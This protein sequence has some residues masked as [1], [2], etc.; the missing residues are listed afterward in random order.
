MCT[1]LPDSNSY[2][3]R[4][5]FLSPF[6][7]LSTLADDGKIES[8]YDMREPGWYV[9][10]A[11]R[12]LRV[13]AETPARRGLSPRKLGRPRS[14]CATM[15]FLIAALRPGYGV[16]SRPTVTGQASARGAV[17]IPPSATGKAPWGPEP[18]PPPKSKTQP[19][20]M[21]SVAAERRRSG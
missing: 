12:I 5:Y 21:P 6:P 2:A 10:N 20:T 15:R 11:S 16:R 3:A 17:R 7:P 19:A 13:S 1:G 8:A 9:A 18:V 4:R 14:L